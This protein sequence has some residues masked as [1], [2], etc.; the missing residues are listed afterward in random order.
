MK[1]LTKLLTGTALA[2][3]LAFNSYSQEIKF[4]CDTL[5]NDEK[6]I[7]SVICI[8]KWQKEL[9]SIYLLNYK[10]N[11][12]VSRSELLYDQNQKIS[13]HK[14]YEKDQ[15]GNILLGWDFN[16]DGSFDKI[17]RKN[18]KKSVIEIDENNDGIFEG[19]T[20][21]ENYIQLFHDFPAQSLNEKYE[22]KNKGFSEK[23]IE[24]N[25]IQNLNPSEIVKDTSSI[26][27]KKTEMIQKDTASIQGVYNP[28]GIKLETKPKTNLEF[29]T[30]TSNETKKDT[31]LTKILETPQIEQTTQYQSTQP[32]KETKKTE[33][34][35]DLEN[36]I[37]AFVDIYENETK[38]TFNIDLDEHNL[39][40][41]TRK[42]SA[43]N[44]LMGAKEDGLDFDPPLRVYVIKRKLT[45]LNGKE[46]IVEDKKISVIPAIINEGYNFEKDSQ[47]KIEKEAKKLLAGMGEK[48]IYVAEPSKIFS[49]EMF[50]DLLGKDEKKEKEK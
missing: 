32:T 1:N 40:Y 38:L 44:L 43:L 25:P 18:D 19:Q 29:K 5:Y 49:A 11:E 3:T 2:T 21:H 14:R 50:F 15:K 42:F 24:P 16:G 6:E 37:L 9:S 27:E 22:H 39:S 23:I 20:N 30:E 28:S 45:K 31:S 46:E 26:K 17:L 33:F 41:E 48:E 35:G 36:V 13:L 12:M 47:K 34:A 4:N 8:G 10:N 7:E